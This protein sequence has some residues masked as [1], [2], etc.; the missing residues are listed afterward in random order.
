MIAKEF[1]FG[2][3]SLAAIAGASPTR[4]RRD[5]G[6][7][8]DLP[9][10]R[11][12]WGVAMDNRLDLPGYKCYVDADGR[13][14]AVF[15]TFLDIAPEAGASVNGVCRPVPG[16]DLEALDRRERNYRRVDVSHLIDAG[17]ARVWTYVGTAAG[18][19]RLRAGRDAGTAVIDAGY[20]AAVRAGFAALGD[21]EQRLCEPSLAADGIPVLPLRR[22]DLP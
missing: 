6:F 7:I 9:G 22:L 8:A 14:P 1:V 2:Y 5:G 12:E 10:F 11:R 17:G 15:V 20:L 3:G 18:R 13:R 21:G 19:Q 16:R 4:R